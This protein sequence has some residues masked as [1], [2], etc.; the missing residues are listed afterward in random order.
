MLIAAA[1]M[2]ATPL[3]LGGAS[4]AGT[5]VPQMKAAQSTATNGAI[6]EKA[7]YRRCA[8]WNVRC[9]RRHGW[10]WKYRRCMVRHGC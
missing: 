2:M 10:G 1:A 8:R 6:V 5:A 4:A 3:M 9:H 7:G